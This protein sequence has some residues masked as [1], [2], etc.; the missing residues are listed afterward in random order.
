[1]FTNFVFFVLNS[2]I[3]NIMMQLHIMNGK[4]KMCG[5]SIEMPDDAIVGELVECGGCGM[6]YEISAI[7]NGNVSL[8]SAEHVGEDWGE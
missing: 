7:S 1:M 8:K 6:T 3:L 5:E 4:C 2:Y